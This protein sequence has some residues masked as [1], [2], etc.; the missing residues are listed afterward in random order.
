MKFIPLNNPLRFLG[1]CCAACCS[2]A[3]TASKALAADEKPY[4]FVFLLADDW[5]FDT[6]GV[7]GNPVVKTPNLD[8]LAG[9]GFRFTNALVTTAICGV[10][11]SSLL[12]GQWMS[13]HGNRSFKTMKSPWA[14]TYPASCAITATTSAMSANGTAGRF[15][16]R[17][18]ISAVPIPAST[19]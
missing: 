14:D 3:A 10:S 9:D 18:S 19:G 6:L 8:K 5:R 7:A 1:V 16:R 13:R 17:S 11:R 2:L 15:P 12:T 4:N